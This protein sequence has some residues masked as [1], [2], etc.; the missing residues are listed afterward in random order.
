MQILEQAQDLPKAGNIKA[1]WVSLWTGGPIVG[2]VLL[3]AAGG[4]S[5]VSG[6]RCRRR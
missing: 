2:V 5:P 1:Q 3:A 6:R 4:A